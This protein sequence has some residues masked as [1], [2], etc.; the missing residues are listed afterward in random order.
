MSHGTGIPT[1]SNTMKEY[2][3]MIIYKWSPSSLSE[4]LNI[5]LSGLSKIEENEVPKDCFQQPVSPWNKGL[6][7]ADWDKE[8]KSI[9]RKKY[10]D[11]S[12]TAK[13]EMRRA[14]IAS[15]KVNKEKLSKE[16]IIFYPDGKSEKIKNLND[17]CKK[18]NLNQGNMC[19]V[20]SGR[21]DSHKGYKCLKL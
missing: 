7:L 9:S 19:S 8:K 17:F 14:N 20:A 1:H 10:L 3:H 13:E 6:K 18:N 15:I 11:T 4:A 2:Q 16:Y 21:L 5:N 12:P